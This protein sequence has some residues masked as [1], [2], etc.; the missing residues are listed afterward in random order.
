[1]EELKHLGSPVEFWEYFY[2]ISQIPRCSGN[3]GRVRDFINNEAKKFGFE[4]EVDEVKNLLVKIPGKN[5]KGKTIILQSHMDIVCEKNKDSTHDFSR[6]P[7][8]LEL[9]EIDDEKWITAKGT[10]LGADNGVGIAYQLAIMKQIYNRQL[11]LDSINLK[12]IYG[13]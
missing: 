13:G 9:I 3:E 5:E 6:D 10:T 4:T 11:N 1:M 8:E 2:E 7:L 12:P